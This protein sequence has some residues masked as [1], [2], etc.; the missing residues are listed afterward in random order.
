VCVCV[1][2]GAETETG[3][4][5]GARPRTGSITAEYRAPFLTLAHTAVL[6]LTLARLPLFYPI[7]HI[8]A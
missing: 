7:S 6:V 8:Y 1:W 4:G 3:E 2:G 5:T